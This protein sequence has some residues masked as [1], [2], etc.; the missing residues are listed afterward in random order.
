VAFKRLAGR[1][2]FFDREDMLR[3][4]SPEDLEEG[5]K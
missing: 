5:E 4:A 1:I 2:E 3:F